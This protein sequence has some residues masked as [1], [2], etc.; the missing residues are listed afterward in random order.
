MLFHPNIF[1]IY[2]IWLNCLNNP[3]KFRETQVLLTFEPADKNLARQESQHTDY[4][5]EKLIC[6]DL[7]H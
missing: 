1:I 4:I 3:T 6:H 7:C 5:Y 2:I